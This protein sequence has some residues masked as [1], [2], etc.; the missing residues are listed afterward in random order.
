METSRAWYWREYYQAH[1]VERRGYYQRNREAILSKK[2][3]RDKLRRE[4]RMVVGSVKLFRGLLKAID[5]VN[6][7]TGMDVYQGHYNFEKQTAT[8]Y[9]ETKDKKAVLKW[10][11]EFVKHYEGGFE[12]EKD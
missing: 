9:C 6:E 2:R 12:D 7:A 3:R 4:A 1:R 10:R 8:L 11:G 5:K